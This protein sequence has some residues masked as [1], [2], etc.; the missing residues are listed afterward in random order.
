MRI[1]LVQHAIENSDAYPLS[2]GYVAAA[3]RQTGHEV[4]F[5]DL[6]LEDGKPVQTL[7]RRVEEDEPQAIGF[8]AMTPQYNECLRLVSKVRPHLPG[9][10]IIL[11]GHHANALPEEVLRDGTADVV[12]VSEGERTAPDLVSKL[13]KGGDLNSVPGIAFLDQQGNFVQTQPREQVANLD[14]IPY[15]PWEILRPEMYR[16]RM[17][18]LK[19]ANLL[20]SRGCPYQCVYCYRGP[21]GGPRVRARSVENVLEEISR[22]YWDHEIGAFGFRDDIF[23]LDMD[24]T[25]ALCDAIVAEKIKIFWD[26][27]TRVDRVD[28]DLLK[29]MKRAGC[30]CVDFGVESGSE[31]ILKK[32]RKKASK[33]EARKA[34]Q[35]CHKVGLPTRAFF[36]LGTPW[37]TPQTV[38]ET[39]SFA[40]EIRP[41]ISVFFLAMPYP[42]T[43][44]R[45]EFAKAGWAIPDNYDEY[46]HWTEG[47]GFM[48]QGGGD[49]GSNV[50]EF[51]AGECRR[52]TRE[53]IMSQVLAVR[54]YPELLRTYLRRYSPTESGI[55]IVRRFRRA[56]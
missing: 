29:Q 11:G 43:E 41:T 5:L 4:D 34:F 30:V 2:L 19:T 37:E 38:E 12:V 20:T 26:C 44:L 25:R 24:R 10:P 13:E 6:A 54:Y 49:A 51:F 3:L 23:T 39:I 7:L 36:L 27:E 45:D 22:L 46:R 32:L 17:R 28:L 14:E 16:G 40:K 9:I 48:F 56:M 35:Y 21:A 53:I 8:T 50:Q 52:A 42:G 47:R 55:H 15:P 31:E 18:G 1:L 33:D